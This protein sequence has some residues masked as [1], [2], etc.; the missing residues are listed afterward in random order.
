MRGRWAQRAGAGVR[1]LL[2]VALLVLTVA[3][4]AYGGNGRPMR[5]RGHGCN[6][7]KHARLRTE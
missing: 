5:G 7:T 2:S 1:A 4:I 6:G 3:G